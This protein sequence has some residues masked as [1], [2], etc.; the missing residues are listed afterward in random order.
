M[1]FSLMSARSAICWMI[2]TPIKSIPRSFA[3]ILGNLG[4]TAS[5]IP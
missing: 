3:R 2:C 1:T 5:R 4:T